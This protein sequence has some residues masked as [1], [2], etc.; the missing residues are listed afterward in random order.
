QDYED[1]LESMMEAFKASGHE[2]YK[3]DTTDYVNQDN[4]ELTTADSL[5][6]TREAYARI[7]SGL[8]SML[9]RQ[10]IR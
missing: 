9:L 6:L 3:F 1:S 2:V 5:H 4:W 10:V 8:A 7:G